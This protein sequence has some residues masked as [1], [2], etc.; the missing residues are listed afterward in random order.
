M[1]LDDLYLGFVPK[2]NVLVMRNYVG[3][4]SLPPE[5]L[6]QQLVKVRRKEMANL[7]IEQ[8][9]IGFGGKIFRNAQSPAQVLDQSH[10][11]SDNGI[12]LRDVEKGAVRTV[13][14][15]V[16]Q[17]LHQAR[18]VGKPCSYRDSRA[19]E[20]ASVPARELVDQLAW[21]H[22]FFCLLRPW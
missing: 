9:L 3:I 4:N 14:D 6:L 17:R 11:A 8:C 15:V 21:N 12:V 5:G 16:G 1:K 2:R 22:G 10:S 7:E 19:H 13:L 20:N 18:P